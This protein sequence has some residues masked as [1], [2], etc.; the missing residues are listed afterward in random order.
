MTLYGVSFLRLKEKDIWDRTA[1]VLYTTRK[2]QHERLK[3]ECAHARI[4][5][6]KYIHAMYGGSTAD[7][8]TAKQ[9]GQHM[10]IFA[11]NVQM[12]EPAKPPP[13]RKRKSVN[14]DQLDQ[15][16]VWALR[17]AVK[18]IENTH[19]KQALRCLATCIESYNRDGGTRGVGEALEMSAFLSKHHVSAPYRKA[20]QAALAILKKSMS[21][22]THGHRLIQDPLYGEGMK[23]W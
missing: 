21:D 8:P 9:S 10:C 23:R 11:C 17:Q 7:F 4:D 22:Y 19:I 14:P 1:F 6:E 5:Y 20:F 15:Q 13:K 16:I 12:G 18:N 2:A 3:A